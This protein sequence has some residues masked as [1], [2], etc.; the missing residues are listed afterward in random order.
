MPEQRPALAVAIY[1]PTG[2]GKSTI[3]AA[4]ATRIDGEV[5]SADAAALYQGLAI[6]TAAPAHPTRLVGVVPLDQTVSVGDYQRL[7]HVAVDEVSAA[8]RVPIVAGGTGLYLR[9]AIGTLRLPPPPQAGE[10]E[11]HARLYDELGPE[12]AYALLLAR[13]PA[14]ASRLHPNDRRRVVR[15]LELAAQGS[16]LAPTEDRL[17]SA[18]TRVPT[19]LVGLALADA[20]LEARVRARISEMVERGV[21]AEARAA[22]KQPL[23]ETAR[24][25]LGLEQFATLPADEAVEATALATLRLARYQRKWL[26]RLT[27]A[28]TLDADR[29]PGEIADEIVALAGARERLPRH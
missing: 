11:R 7:A 21:V 27:V 5:I 17:W 3:A 25:V 12:G 2:S 29:P 28:A 19:V 15:A 9:A 14:A 6:L 20:V 1:G 13:D 8:G 4:L 23:S 18:D 16:S 24:R 22:W 26:R 10:R